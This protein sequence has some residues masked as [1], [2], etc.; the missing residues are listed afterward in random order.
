[1]KCTSDTTRCGVTGRWVLA[2]AIGLLLPAAPGAAQMPQEPA[3]PTTAAAT[4]GQEGRETQPVVEVIEFVGLVR[5]SEAFARGMVAVRVGDGVD[6]ARLQEDVARLV[7]SGRFLSASFTTEPGARGTRVRFLLV[8]RPEVS[9]LRFEGNQKYKDRKLARLVPLKVGATLDKFLLREGIEAITRLYR[10]AGYGDVAVSY[11]EQRAEQSGEVV[12]TIVEGVRAR[13]REIEFA[14]ATAFGPKQLQKQ[15][16]T[17]TALWIFRKGAYDADQAQ[18]DTGSL[19]NFYRDE[20]Y[21]DARV[22]H[23]KE[24]SPDGQDITVVFTI[25]EGTCYHIEAVHLAGYSVYTESELRAL[26]GSDPGEIIKRRQTD[27]DAKALRDHY[28]RFGYIYAEV[29]ASTVFSETPGLVVLTFQVEEE[30]QY[31]VGRVEPR[32]NTRTKDKVVRRALN[33][34]PPDDLIDMTEVREAERRLR[35][36]GNFDTARIYPVGDEP[37]RRDLIMDVKETEK[38]GDILFGFGVS[39][40]SGLVGSLVLDVKNFDLFDTPRTFSELIRF[41]AFHGAGQRL[42]LEFQPGTELTRFR[43]DFTEPYLWDRPLRLDTSVYLFSRGRDTY[44]E[45]RAGGNVGLGKRFER[46]RWQ[47]WTVE[48]ALRGEMVTIDDAEL[49]APRDVHEVEG[50]SVLSSVRTTVVHDR[51]DNR[52]LPTRGDRVRLGFEQ[53]AGDYNFGKL[54]GGYTWCKTLYTDVL[55]RPSVLTLDAET[56]FIVGDAPIFER[57]FAGGFGSLRGFKFRGVG[58]WKGIEKTNVGGDFLL[59]MTGEY[60]FPLYGDVLRGLVFVDMG[61]VEPNLGISSWRASVGTG[62]RLTLNFFG[63]LPLEF[64]LAAPIAKDGDDEEQWFSFYIGSAF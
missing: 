63:P 60:S 30:G 22:G 8:E 59:T 37:D 41:R 62:I 36:S 26:V 39:S 19:E 57:F 48:G 29:R 43:V 64:D 33:L 54:T 51:R 10:D 2:A 3:T 45:Q 28:G 40:N 61:T 17:K 12:I 27:A 53:A 58:P 44:D 14:G 13:V 50:D 6:Q 16:E 46:G 42:R 32:G 24:V 18:R 21:L 23:R 20:G 31:R 55:E 38:A 5:T 52:F 15:I 25:E 11:D 35:E 56:G 1:M 47:G 7:R 34:Y 49:F 4:A 9:A